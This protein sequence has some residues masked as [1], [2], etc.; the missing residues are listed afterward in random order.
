MRHQNAAFSQPAVQEWLLY[1]KRSSKTFSVE[2]TGEEKNYTVGG[3]Y[4]YSGNIDVSLQMDVS[5]G[6][7]ELALKADK[8]SPR[9]R[10]L[11]GTSP[12]VGPIVF[13]GMEIGS[14]RVENSHDEDKPVIRVE[15]RNPSCRLEAFRVAANLVTCPLFIRGLE[16]CEVVL[17]DYEMLDKIGRKTLPKIRPGRHFVGSCR[18]LNFAP[19]PVGRALKEIALVVA[20]AQL[21]VKDYFMRVAC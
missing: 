21:I 3:R 5:G 13:A 10:Q 18:A 15:T 2:I 11:F 4:T 7:L 6:C 16:D 19:D 1:F 17:E 8:S 12:L 9:N 14:C 20:V